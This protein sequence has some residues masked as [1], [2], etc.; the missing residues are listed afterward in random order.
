[1]MPP[2]ELAAPAAPA[3]LAAVEAWLLDQGLTGRTE[4][5]H[6]LAG[7]IDRG[8]AETIQAAIWFSDLEGF[9]RLADTLP[10]EQL[11][12]FLNAYVEDL[13]A[14]IHAHG[15]QVLKFVGDGM[16]AI[17]PVGGP[18]AVA[19]SAAIEAAIDAQRRA[20]RLLAER[21]DFT[22]LGPAVNETARIERM[23]RTLEQPIVISQSLA[24]AACGDRPHLV[25]L[26]R[27]MLRGVARA[28]ELFTLDPDHD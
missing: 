16:L 9:T 18:A 22:V 19:P 2:G 21:L 23:C 24:N 6:V 27:Y 12:P 1:M 25:S 5:D 11:I 15:G 8:Q 28:Q 13:V 20:D 7:S 14:A 17:F 26:G 4:A 10:R 3:A